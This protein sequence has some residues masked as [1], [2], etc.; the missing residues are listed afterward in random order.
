MGRQTGTH[1]L[2]D[3][4]VTHEQDIPKTAHFGVPL[5]GARAGALYQ[6]NGGK[7]KAGITILKQ[8]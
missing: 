5:N 8:G 6:R 1:C 3:Q 2:P 7:P 4:P